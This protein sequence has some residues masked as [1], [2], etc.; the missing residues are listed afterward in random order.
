MIPN[1]FLKEWSS[2]FILFSYVLKGCNLDISIDGYDIGGWVV[3]GGQELTIERPAYE[4]K[5]F[6]FYRVKA[7]PKEAGIES[8]RSK[9]GVVKCVFTPEA[10]EDVPVIIPGCP[11]PLRVDIAPSGTV[12]DLKREVQMQLNTS[13]DPDQ[14]L[15]LNDRVLSNYIR[16]R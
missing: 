5:R 7:A 3:D 6:T 11:E 13:P 2:N 8:G 10:F 14:I 15:A 1:Q 4:A 16:L 12:D 9:N